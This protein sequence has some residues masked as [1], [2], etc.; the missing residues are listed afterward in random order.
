MI[1]GVGGFLFG[2]CCW[3]YYLSICG[4]LFDC[5]RVGLRGC[6]SN[7]KYPIFWVWA[8]LFSPGVFQPSG[9]AETYCTSF[10]ITQSL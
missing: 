10:Q 6:V 7:I 2:G 9:Q 8:L 1:R 5:K 4:T 3:I